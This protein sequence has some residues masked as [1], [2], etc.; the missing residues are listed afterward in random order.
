MNQQRRYELNAMLPRI[1][2]DNEPNTIEDIERLIASPEHFGSDAFND[3]DRTWLRFQM[4]DR[5]GIYTGRERWYP[6]IEWSIGVATMKGPAV[7]SVA[8]NDPEKMT[9][10]TQAYEMFL[11][12][13]QRGY[14]VDF[15]GMVG[16]RRRAFVPNFI[17]Q[18]VWDECFALISTKT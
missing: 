6:P 14:S 8:E 13:R 12:L 16:T 18:E 4:K 10:H 2:D 1:I 15:G 7:A 5:Y 9:L 11:L 3:E 17:P